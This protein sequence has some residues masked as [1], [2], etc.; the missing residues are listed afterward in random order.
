[1]KSEGGVARDDEGAAEARKVSGEILGYAV[2]EIVLGWVA[3][4]IGERQH[5]DGQMRGLG[6]AVRA[7]EIPG[8]GRDNDERHDPGDQRQERGALF[9]LGERG[10]GCRFRLGGDA[11]L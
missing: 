11:H 1:M 7:E 4:K 2:G 5:D 8:P 9:R 6:G 3:G 10:P